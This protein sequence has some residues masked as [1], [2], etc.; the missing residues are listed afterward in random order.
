MLSCGNYGLAILLGVSVLES[1]TM[2]IFSANTWW[3]LD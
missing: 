2:V 1:L 3:S